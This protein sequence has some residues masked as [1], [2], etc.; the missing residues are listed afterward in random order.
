MLSSPP[1]QHSGGFMSRAG[2]SVG[3]CSGEGHKRTI[4]VGSAARNADATVREQRY[5]LV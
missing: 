4:Y 5:C 3:Y 2:V 1:P